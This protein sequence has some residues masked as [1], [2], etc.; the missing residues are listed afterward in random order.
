MLDFTTAKQAVKKRFK[1]KLY[2]SDT[3]AD[4]EVLIVGAGIAGI[5]GCIELGDS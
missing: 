5:R 3:P 4:Y 1:A 2:S